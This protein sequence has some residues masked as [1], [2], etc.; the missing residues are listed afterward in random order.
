MESFA[1]NLWD[2]HPSCEIFDTTAFIQCFHNC[3]HGHVDNFL[4]L[5]NNNADQKIGMESNEEA[6]T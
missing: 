5:K 4:F 3:I 6:I 2:F 1:T